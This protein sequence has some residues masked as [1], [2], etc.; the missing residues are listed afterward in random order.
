MGGRGSSSLSAMQ[1]GAISMIR[2]LDSRIEAEKKKLGVTE[3][4][5]INTFISTSTRQMEA[6]RAI[7]NAENSIDSL[8]KRYNVL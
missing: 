5:G 8:K 2:S 3:G 6:K 4:S 1:K 7:R